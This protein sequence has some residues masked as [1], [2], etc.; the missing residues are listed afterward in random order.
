MIHLINLLLLEIQEVSIFHYLDN[1]KIRQLSTKELNIHPLRIPE[2]G[3]REWSGRNQW[4]IK[5][6]FSEVKNEKNLQGVLA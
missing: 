3:Q 5:E 2:R 1:N 4:K 6:S